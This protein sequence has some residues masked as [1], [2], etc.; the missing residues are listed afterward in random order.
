VSLF[1]PEI[2]KALGIPLNG[3]QSQALNMVK[4]RLKALIC[5]VDLEVAHTIFPA[6]IGFSE[7]YSASFNIIGRK[8]FFDRFGVYFDE[9]KRRIGLVVKK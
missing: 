6:F 5:Q 2:A 7:K 4:G 8:D 1:R 3:N 9:S